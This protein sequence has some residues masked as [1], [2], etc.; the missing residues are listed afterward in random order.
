[1]YTI[2]QILEIFEGFRM[3]P[4]PI[5]QYETKGK[6]ILREKLT[7]FVILNK[8]IDFVMLGFPFKST[9]IR[10]KVLGQLPDAAE[11]ETLR[12]FARFNAAVKAVYEPGVNIHI[13]SDGFVFNDVLKVPDHVVYDYKSIS[14]SLAGEAPMHWYDINDFYTGGDLATKR[15]T[16]IQ[17]F[18]ITPEKLQFEIMNNPDVN[19]LYRGMVRFMEEELA[20][21]T[22]ASNNQHTKAAKEL[23]R[24]MM[25][26]NEAYSNL[27]KHEFSNMVRLS[28]HP[29]INNGTKYSFQLIPGGRHSAWHCALVVTKEGAIE[30]MHR[31]D[32]ILAGHELVYKDNRPYFFMHK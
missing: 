6:E 3:T 24:T 29:S 32:A 16:V 14:A 9:N 25:F 5:D 7:S 19:Y 18:G 21:Q 10:D 12:N 15:S 30:T 26:R 27:V 2:N 4:T 8:P 23:A 1:M 20:M 31:K 22:F 13:V 11:E 28:M 17:Q